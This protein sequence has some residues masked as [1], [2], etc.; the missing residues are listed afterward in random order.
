M[1]KN[2]PYLVTKKLLPF[3]NILI[4][5][6]CTVFLCIVCSPSFLFAQSIHWTLDEC[7]AY[8]LEHNIEIKSQELTAETKRVTFSESKW[9]YAPSVSASNSYNLSTGRVLDPT[10]YDFIENQTV[11]GNSTSLSAGITLFSGMGNLHNM[12]RAKLDLRSSLLGV[13]KTRNDITLN[14][15]AYYLEILCAQE[16]IRNAEQIVGS[17]KIQE[18]KTAKQVEA[19][20]VTMADLLQIQSQLAEAENNVFTARNTYDIARLNLCQLLE[21]DNY[22]SFETMMPDENLP[23]ISGQPQEISPVIDAA[24]TLPQ[25]QMARLDIDIAQR[26]VCIARAAYYPTISLSAAYGSSYSD[27]R[28]KAL[29]NPDGTYRYD[30]YPFFEQY[31]DNANSYISLSLS[32]PIFGGFQKRKSVRK[33]QLAARQAEYALR[34]MEK[35]VTKEVNQAW[36]D[37]RTAWEK[38]LSSQKYVAT[39]TEAARQVERKYDLGVATVVDYNTSLDNLVKAKSQFLQAKYEYI[40]KTKLI[41]FYLNQR[42]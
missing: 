27:A 31:K 16:N 36:I 7:I 33:A 21:I 20:K 5:M 42:S 6:R 1:A 37:M 25:M 17:L 30:A 10:T 38:Y 14:I 18:E 8:A 41:R 11:Q 4:I 40:F 2:S 24:M 39:A 19:R 15:T 28:Q 29:Q 32:V 34:T 22:T 26:D 3:T 12:K 9:A 35:Q 13:E 23:E